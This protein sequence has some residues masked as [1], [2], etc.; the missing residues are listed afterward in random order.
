MKI[1]QKNLESTFEI[2]PDVFE[3]IDQSR[4]FLFDEEP[5]E[6]MLYENQ[7]ENTPPIAN[8]YLSAQVYIDRIIDAFKILDMEK[9]LA[10]ASHLGQTDVPISK[11]MCLNLSVFIRALVPEY[12]NP[13]LNSDISTLTPLLEKIW[14]IALQYRDQ[15]LQTTIGEPHYRCYEHYG[16]YKDA[17]RVLSVLIKIGTKKKHPN[18]LAIL[19][20]NFAFEYQLEKQWEKAMFYFEKASQIFKENGNKIQHANSRSNY[21]ACYLESIGFEKVEKIETELKSFVKILD[22]STYWHRRKPLILLARI[23]EKRGNIDVAL[24][25][26]EKALESS[27][28]N[29]TRYPEMD[30]KYL[31][32]LKFKQIN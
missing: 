10:T 3:E 22:S 25:L 17:R 4:V 1:F 21:W 29:N 11:T 30:K 7:P 9:A 26:V 32:K 5:T 19:I 12:P 2:T 8:F 14:R 18:D 24:K 13:I 16:R 20:N 27:Q 31:D 23:E 28:N 6:N 15:E